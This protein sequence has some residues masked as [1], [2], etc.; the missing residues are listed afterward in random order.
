VT[1]VNDDRDHRLSKSSSLRLEKVV[2]D[3]ALREF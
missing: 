2:F 1:T 3:P